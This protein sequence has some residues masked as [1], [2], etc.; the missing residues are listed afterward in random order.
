MPLD[1]DRHWYRY[2]HLFAEVLR[3]RLQRS[4]APAM[5]AVLHAR[6]SV[7]YEQEGFIAEAVHHALAAADG[8]RTA[9]LIE[10]QGLRLIVS[11][12]VQ[13]VLGWLRQLPDTM[14]RAHPLLDIAYAL[15]LLFTNE[16]AAAEARLQEIERGIGPNTAPAEASTMQGYA[17]AI[18][19]NIALYSGDLAACVASGEQVLRCLPLTETIARTTAQL[20]VARSYRVTGDVSAAAERRALA[21]VD[22]IRRTG[23]LLGTVGAVSN[24]ARLQALQGRLHAAATTYHEL[25]PIGSGLEELRALHGGVAYFVALGDLHCE[26]NEFDT[27]ESFLVQALERLAGTRTVDAEDVVQGYLAMARLQHA[28]GDHATAE[29]ILLTVRD[30]ARERGFVPHLL[31]RV[32][33][34]QAHLTLVAGN[35]PATITWATTSGL[36][37]DDVVAF[38]QEAQYLILARIWIAQAAHGASGPMLAQVLQ[39]L[40]RLLEDA[41]VKKRQDSAITILIVQALGRWAQGMHGEAL[42][43]IERALMLAEPEGYIRRFVD[44]GPEIETILRTA[45]ASGIAQRYVTRLLAAFPGSTTPS[46]A[47]SLTVYEAGN[48]RLS[49]RELEVLRL[50]ASGTSNVE[51]A[52]QLVIAVSTVKSHVNNIFGKLEATSRSEALQRARELHLIER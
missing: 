5:T 40:E 27:A 3:L 21:A 22:P 43:S 28:R 24:V 15:A 45:F 11:G 47:G 41:T 7:W 37:A 36:H 25:V 13:M 50:I 17:A 46:R 32:S 39:L 10:E 38:P 14:F 18:R 23:S 52:R 19:A 1:D 51:I 29:R 33:A 30:V 26:W 44:E 20:H 8:T 49:A 42:Q 16:L 34:A 48:E 4:V 2:H 31:A 6:A 12:Q 35:L 9:R